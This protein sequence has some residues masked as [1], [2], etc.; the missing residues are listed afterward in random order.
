MHLVATKFDPMFLK[1]FYP[2]NKYTQCY[3]LGNGGADRMA[4]GCAYYECNRCLS[5]QS[6]ATSIESMEKHD[7]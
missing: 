6:M 7:A 1:L 5:S 2:N 3:V 4:F